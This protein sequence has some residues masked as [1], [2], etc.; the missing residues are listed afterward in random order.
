ALSLAN[1]AIELTDQGGG[2]QEVDLALG[3]DHPD[4]S[5]PMLGDQKFV[6]LGHRRVLTVDLR[7]RHG[8]LAGGQRHLSPTAWRAYHL[9]RTPRHY[10]SP[11]F[12]ATGSA[13]ER[14]TSR[15]SRSA[16]S[17]PDPPSRGSRAS[18]APAPARPGSPWRSP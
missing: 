1:S 9:Q 8:E 13:G 2:R 17:A 10:F 3:D 12:P 14:A 7:S 5:E 16:R 4:V 11:Q 6:R 15:G 18:R